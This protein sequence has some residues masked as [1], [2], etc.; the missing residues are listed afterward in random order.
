[1]KGISSILSPF[2]VLVILGRY[3]VSDYREKESLN[4]SV[5]DIVMHPDWDF[6]SEK[7]D[8]DIAILILNETITLS[9]SI[10]PICLPQKS[11]QEFSGTGTVVG[12]G[13]S[14]KGPGV[15]F[16]DTKPNKVLMPAINASHCFTTSYKIAQY[17]S[18]RAFCAGFENEGKGPCLGD[19]G[20]GY[21]FKT[22]SSWVMQGIVSGSLIKELDCD[23]N[24]FSI[25]TS[26]PWFV[27]WI[28]EVMNDT[29]ERV[30]QFIEYK[31]SK[32]P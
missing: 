13:K 22:R 29:K 9:D 12:Y 19:S 1:M 27:D 6:L 8:A 30:W 20:S 15:A 23:V 2:E 14:E 16:H 3:N 21:Y 11:F 4:S 25:Y 28:K 17:T 18:K 26:V 10:R 24:T 31:C 32:R 5:L 7:Y